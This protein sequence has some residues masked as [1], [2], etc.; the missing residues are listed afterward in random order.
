MASSITS[1]GFITVNDRQIYYEEEGRA[2]DQTIFFVHGLGGTLNTFQPLICSLR[3]FHVIRF[4]LS[5]HGRSSV[6]SQKTSIETYVEDCKAVISHLK[7]KKA[8]VVGHS[9]GCLIAM[10]LAAIE[11]NLAS[12]LVLFGP[13]KGLPEAVKSANR[14]RAAAVR[15]KGMA[16]AADA[17][18]SA[19]L[20]PQTLSSRP[21][22]VGYV[23]EL[24]SRQDKEGYAMGCEALAAAKDPD[25]NQIRTNRVVI[26][27][28]EEDKVSAPA[29]CRAIKQSLGDRGVELI[30]WP[31]VGHWHT[32]EKA[33]EA[34]QLVKKVAENSL[35]PNMGHLDNLPGELLE[36][37]AS[38]LGKED[39]MNLRA[40][41]RTF[42]FLNRRIFQTAQF[43]GS[44]TDVQN[45]Q[46]MLE[47]PHIYN[48]LR[49]CFF[50]TTSENFER[51]LLRST[52]R[53]EQEVLRL[54]PDFG[55]RI[56]EFRLMGNTMAMGYM[57]DIIRA[58]KLPSLKRISIFWGPMIDS[59]VG[60][61][62]EILP[63]GSGP[64]RICHC[65]YV[66]L[67]CM[68]C[69]YDGFKFMN[70]EELQVY[71]TWESLG[72]SPLSVRAWG[73][74]NVNNIADCF[75]PPR[76][77]RRILLCDCRVTLSW[78]KNTVL[79]LPAIESIALL[80]VNIIRRAHLLTLGYESYVLPAKE[81]QQFAEAFDSKYEAQESRSIRLYSKPKEDS[82]N[83]RIDDTHLQKVTLISEEQADIFRASLDDESRDDWK[84]LGSFQ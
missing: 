67:N 55:L 13:A 77:L 16:A 11:Q 71:G 25:W 37:I 61:R 29:T 27:S 46:A 18:A 6:P 49:R 2:S 38:Y 50:N 56:E 41:S 26:V 12:A 36:H 10:H 81:W 58:R 54:L 74:V 48:S 3:N 20:A 33:A 7:V 31:R 60:E 84:I 39:W 65:M 57:L 45:L 73:G 5:G 51:T 53:R 44:T 35:G 24:L 62:G 32:L 72:G 8:V 75:T 42:E 34:G 21:E 78:L 22:I 9:M 28:G 15:Q 69:H 40:T 80:H 82:A 76:S 59:D 68:V 47:Q 23:R 14:N 4:D 1:N 52:V 17:I 70:L 19:A 66:T 64:S 83:V 79:R 30:S 43:D 63:I